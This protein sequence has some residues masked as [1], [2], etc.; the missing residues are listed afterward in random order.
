MTVAG[1]IVDQCCR[2]DHRSFGTF[3]V[4]D[5][6]FLA[7]SMVQTTGRQ[8]VFLNNNDCEAAQLKS[9]ETLSKLLNSGNC[10]SKHMSCPYGWNGTQPGLEAG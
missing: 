2:E 5:V 7:W 4:K 8:H 3:N 10:Q 9:S 6:H 1:A